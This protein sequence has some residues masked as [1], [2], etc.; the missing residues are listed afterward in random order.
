MEILAWVYQK[1]RLMIYYSCKAANDVELA[2]VNICKLYC[3]KPL[4]KIISHE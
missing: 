2:Q 3:I 4:L 1:Q